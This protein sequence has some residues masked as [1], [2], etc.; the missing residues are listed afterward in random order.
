MALVKLVSLGALV[1]AIAGCELWQA[2]PFPPYMRDIV[3]ER[4]TANIFPT[5]SRGPGEAQVTASIYQR[6][7]ELDQ[8]RSLFIIAYPNGPVA[9]ID[10]DGAELAVFSDD[11]RVD[12]TGVLFNRRTTVPTV[13][14]VQLGEL[15]F[16]PAIPG[17]PNR[18]SRV[19]NRAAPAGTFPQPLAVI[20]L[21]E[22]GRYH[23]LY[24]DLTE[25]QRPVML[26]RTSSSMSMVEIQT[27]G[28]K[29]GE[30]FLQK[31]PVFQN[32][33]ENVGLVV[34]EMT[35][36]TTI[37]RAVNGTRERAVWYA[38]RAADPGGAPRI[39]VGVQREDVF[40]E[41]FDFEID[42]DDEDS[43]EKTEPLFSAN[44]KPLEQSQRIRF[45][46]IHVTVAGIFAQD[47]ITGA[48]LQY[49]IDTGKLLQTYPLDDPELRAVV[50]P[51]GT[52]ML[53]FD[54]RRNRVFILRRWWS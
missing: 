23:V 6:D 17:S 52:G 18:P 34:F 4:D 35:G 46:S 3:Y 24:R 30:D 51:G 20:P 1:L 21:G 12:R 36:G 15:A 28:S 38:V 50:N 37:L 14:T 49:S 26:A 39:F 53:L 45:G 5:G 32:D 9:W 11:Q 2:N 7:V 29:A 42:D 47:N 25:N 40:G 16:T 48:V 13:F 8:W 41:P 44:H 27:T 31:I 33:S 43:D 54:S 22:S 10:Q 19:T